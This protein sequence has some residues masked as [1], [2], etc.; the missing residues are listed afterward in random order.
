M[1]TT[2]DQPAGTINN[3]KAVTEANNVSSGLELDAELSDTEFFNSKTEKVSESEVEKKEVT[4]K[5]FNENNYYRCYRRCRYY[6]YYGRLYRRCYRRCYSYLNFKKGQSNENNEKM[7]DSEF[8]QT[9]PKLVSEKLEDQKE[10]DEK[11]F[12]ANRYRCYIRIRYY[13]SHGRL[14]RVYYKRC[15]RYLND[16]LLNE[17]ESNLV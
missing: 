2:E 16:D 9:K 5:E 17:A 13:R 3:A 12:Q 14:Y 10:V 7:T 6:R 15:Y 4:E 1:T 11:E 8:F